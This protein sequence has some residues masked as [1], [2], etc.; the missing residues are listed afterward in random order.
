[1][2]TITDPGHIPHTPHHLVVQL[3][4]VSHRLSTPVRMYVD[5][6]RIYRR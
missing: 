6:V 1:V 3:D 4:A 5:Y 2:R